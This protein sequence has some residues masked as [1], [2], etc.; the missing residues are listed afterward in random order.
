MAPL[1]T[2]RS[3]TMTIRNM[4]KERAK[5]LEAERR[6]RGI[7]LNRTVLPLPEE[8]LGISKDRVRS[9]GLCDLAATWSE[10]EFEHFEDAVVPFGELDEEL[11]K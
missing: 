5:A 7:S 9:N 6:C 10:D 4:S 3:T 2:P 1:A 11:W 8:A